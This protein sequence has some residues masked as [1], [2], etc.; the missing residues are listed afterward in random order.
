MRK[1]FIAV[2]TLIILAAP[3]LSRAG[4]P[5]LE[6][7]NTNPSN[8]RQAKRGCTLPTRQ[9]LKSIRFVSSLS[10]SDRN[11][12]KLYTDGK[13][14]F[15]RFLKPLD[16]KSYPTIFIGDGT[17]DVIT[18]YHVCGTTAILDQRI[19]GGRITL[20]FRHSTIEMA[21]SRDESTR[22]ASE[23]TPKE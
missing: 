12:L 15:I 19:D 3:T 17:G 2:L 18:P 5:K 6:I 13:K 1:K 9:S 22:K 10:G 23:R 16:K 11:F 14:T 21:L 7:S 20:W 8:S 4:D